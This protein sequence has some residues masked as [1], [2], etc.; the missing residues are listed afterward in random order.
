NIGYATENEGFYV[1]GAEDMYNP[2]G[3]LCRW[4]GKRKTINDEFDPMES[5][6]IA[7]LVNGDI[8]ECPGKP[9]LTKG[10]SWGESFEK[11]GGGYGYNMTYLGSRLWKKGIDWRESYQMTTKMSEV[12]MPVNTLMFADCA[13]SMGGQLIEYSFAEQPFVMSYGT[14][15][16]G[17]S[18][19]EIRT[20]S[21]SIHFRHRNL[22]N[23]GWADGH[24]GSM[25]M[26]QV[27]TGN[28]GYG[29]DS[30]SVNLGW[31]DPADNSL[32]DLK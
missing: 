14:V 20:L 8:K 29:V 10:S 32:F 13:M 19:M 11:G 23:V 26:S 15:Y 30:S 6:L 31:F 17:S 1:P 4:H 9:R 21:P 7:Y 12:K 22:T 25:R 27:D 28:N 16:D 5:P 3:G 18:G 2:M 24:V